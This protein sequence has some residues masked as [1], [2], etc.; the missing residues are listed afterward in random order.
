MML[1][2]V[3]DDFHFHK[4]VHSHGWLALRPYTYDAASGTLYR[5]Q[6][7]P[8]GRV[9]RLAWQ[10]AENAV[11][12]LL[13]TGITPPSDYLTSLT[14]R[15]FSMDWDLAPFYEA[16]RRH[17]EY[18]W[19]AEKN[20]GRILTSPTVWE[21]LAKTLLTTNTTWSQTIGM[22]ERLCQLGDR[23]EDGS[24]AFPTPQQV[25]ELSPEVLQA[26][27]RAGYRSAY[28]HA[29]AVEIAEGRLDVEAWYR[30]TATSDDLYH[31]IRNIKGF[32]DYAAGTMLRLLGRFDRVAIDSACRSAHARY[33]NQGVKADDKTIRAHYE[34]FGAWR[35]LVMWMDVMREDF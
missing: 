12:V 26:Q 30:S 19:I 1:V 4:T 14:R 27:I 17:P 33:Y 23:A 21:D 31:A 28:L 24:H 2:P 18:V 29:L 6:A 32:G 10:S 3:D 13:P 20:V 9:A 11:Q 35:G 22:V 5:V 7:L 25:A 8:D 34:P 16:I 15:I